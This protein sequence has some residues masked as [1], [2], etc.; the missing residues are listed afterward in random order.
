MGKRTFEHLVLASSALLALGSATAQQA[1]P[2]SAEESEGVA[3]VVVTASKREQN[4]QEASVAVT[5]VGSDRLTT[6]QVNNIQ[7]LQTIVP[8]VN[9]GSDF[10]Q[11]K[12]FI[13]G[14]GANTSTT[15]SSTGVAFHVDGAYVARAEAQLTSLFD[16]KRIEVLRGPQGTLYGRNAVGGSINVI[17]AGPTD[18]LEGY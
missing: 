15:G 12:I 16:V 5:A 14:V 17:T 7:D 4:L 1:E 13:R 3:E 8:S 18:F 2:A 11:A 9:F 6:G 10:N